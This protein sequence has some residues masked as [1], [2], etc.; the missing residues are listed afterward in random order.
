MHEDAHTQEELT[1]VEQR[2]RDFADRLPMIVWQQNSTGAVTFANVAWY[3]ITGLPREPASNTAASWV[4][5]IHPDDYQSALNTING[6]VIPRSAFQVRFRLKSLHAGNADYR[7]YRADALP[8]YIDGVF[9][10]WTGYTVDIHDSYDGNEM[11]RHLFDAN[12]IGIFV[13]KLTGEICIANA[14][15]LRMIGYTEEE[16]AAGHINWHQMTPAKWVATDNQAVEELRAN[17]VI[18]PFEKEYYRKDGTCV[19]LLL[20]GSQLPGPQN[21]VLCYALDLSALKTAEENLA[22]TNAL[23][24]Q[25]EQHFK[26]MASAI[27]V[28]TWTADADGWIDWYNSQWYEYTGSDPK[29]A[30]GWG[31]QSVHHP[32]YFP[33]VMQTWPESIATGK[34]FEMEFPLK[35]HDGVYNW[36][37]TRV[38]PYSDHTGR[39]IRW[40]GS[41]VDIQAQKES[42]SR[43]QRISGKLQQDFVPENL[44]RNEYVRFD[45][46]YVAAEKDASV[47]GDWFEAVK[48]PT[49]NFLIA[50][51]DV[52]GHGIEASVVASKLRQAVITS[53]LSEDSPVHI[54][55]S[56]NQV[57]RFQ[58]PEVYATALV[59]IIDRDCTTFS[60]SSAGHPPP[61]IAYESGVPPVTLP[62]GG[63]PLGVDD[64][65]GLTLQHCDLRRDAVLA[66]YTDGLIEFSRDTEA[67]EAKLRQELAAL[68]GNT[69]ASHAAAMVKDRVLDGVAPPDDIALLLAQFSYAPN[70][71][72]EQSLV[73][74]EKVWRFHSSDAYT[75]H[76][77]RK[78][79][80][81]FIRSLASDKNELY[82]SELILGEILANTVDHAPGLVE[83][84]INW[85]GAKPLVTVR[86]T[87]PGFV[88][89]QT[90]LPVDIWSESGRGLFLIGALAQNVT[91]V[92]AKDGGAELRVTLPITR[93]THH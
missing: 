53:A 25:S 3:T 69:T 18:Q 31:W 83:I 11:F 13:A 35:R 67:A 42:L 49:G 46:V 9:R 4:R 28:I 23:V 29:A 36:F 74:L 82:A 58:H 45:S 41:N 93:P 57:L 62:Y 60:Y 66:L 26:A 87:G 20:G 14:D 12:V 90:E 77:S 16:L 72:S 33:M 51:G 30:V 86:D 15:F 47:G 37:L 92:P 6:A 63:L 61:I 32:E 19:P 59:G 2:F 71:A 70:I 80:M 1:L 21:E 76:L 50:V 88:S 54:L 79:L 27:P 85:H 43:A 24:A 75:T 17:G 38:Q 44:P 55:H 8:E 78:E 40:Y 48:L 84:S 5:V 91:V 64:N 73:I 81:T 56:V 68:V 7:W 52:A 89:L 39:V 34:P 65:L 10:G 22:L